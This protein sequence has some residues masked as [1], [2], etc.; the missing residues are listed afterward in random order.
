MKAP[1]EE[2]L[3]ERQ[4]DIIRLLDEL[5]REDL[6]VD[7]GSEVSEL[8]EEYANND[9]LLGELV[10]RYASSPSQHV[11][12]RITNSIRLRMWTMEPSLATSLA[13]KIVR[14]HTCHL[15]SGT[16]NMLA[17][18]LDFR[19]IAAH[20]ASGDMLTDLKKL[21]DLCLACEPPNHLWPALDLLESL[22]EEGWLQHVVLPGERGPTVERLS[23]AF[24][25][26]GRLLDED[27]LECFAKVTEALS[28]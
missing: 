3:S 14:V 11:V 13:L 7:D 20:Q 1:K 24:A 12:S 9:E 10:D 27:Y 15:G 28:Q 2:G 16:L 8:I 17:A 22:L 25:R 21:L 18:P 6:P 5:E 4:R 26:Y 19:V 23:T